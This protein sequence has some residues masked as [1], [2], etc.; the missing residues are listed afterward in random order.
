MNRWVQVKYK[1][2][3]LV[4]IDRAHI[5]TRSV[6]VFGYTVWRTFWMQLPNNHVVKLSKL[7]DV[8]DTNKLLLK[9]KCFQNCD[10]TGEKC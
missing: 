8:T 3:K 1:R 6:L 5:I 10:S 7:L 4:A 2:N 9:F